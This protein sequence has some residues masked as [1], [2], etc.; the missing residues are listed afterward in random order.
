MT[1]FINR[2]KGKGWLML[3]AM[4][5]RRKNQTLPGVRKDLKQTTEEI[6]PTAAAV[7]VE[8]VVQPAVDLMESKWLK[9]LTLEKQRKDMQAKDSRVARLA[10]LFDS[11][12]EQEQRL[13]QL[14]AKDNM[15][16][17]L[18]KVDH[19]LT[20]EKALITNWQN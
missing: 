6:N 18:K 8:E 14:A 11:D 4:S 7:S 19:H 1:E 15:A 2:V 16:N 5:K 10:T 12:E 17:F 13:D 3:F 20:A 9:A